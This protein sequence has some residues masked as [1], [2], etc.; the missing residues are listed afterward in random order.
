MWRI[1][2]CRGSWRHEIKR[3]TE[4]SSIRCGANRCLSTGATGNCQVSTARLN[5]KSIR[6]NEGVNSKMVWLRNR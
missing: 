6:P 1:T 5:W 4:A 2:A 3:K